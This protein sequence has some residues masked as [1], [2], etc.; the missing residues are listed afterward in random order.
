[1]FMG[2]TL[3]G[4][5][6]F[7]Q[8]FATM[9]TIAGYTSIAAFVGGAALLI[10]FAAGLLHARRARRSELAVRVPAPALA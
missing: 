10:L 4:M 9:G 3:R 7:G 5:L 8:A 6:L 2:N 1:M